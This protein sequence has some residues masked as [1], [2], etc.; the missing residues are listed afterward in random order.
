MEAQ[1]AALFDKLDW[2]WEYEKFSLM[3]PSGLTYIPDFWVN[4]RRLL[5]ECR[6]YESERGNRQIDE[7]VKLVE[8]CE[9][10]AL[11]PDGAMCNFMLIGQRCAFYTPGGL[12]STPRERWDNV[13][14]TQ[15]PVGV[16]WGAEVTFCRCGWIPAGM[17]L[18]CWDC[19]SMATRAAIIS[20]DGGK[21]L[22]N[23]VAVEDL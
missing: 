22:L 18:F 9:F 13:A 6:G 19:R 15:R 21:V 10:D 11:L 1:C 5:I 4:D 12:N 17:S 14:A 8:D 23:G 7:T 3:L 20:V 16:D 2:P